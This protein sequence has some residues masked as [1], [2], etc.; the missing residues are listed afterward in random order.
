MT[1]NEALVWLKTLRQRHGE[2]VTLRDENAHSERRF[3]GNAGKE[4]EKT[5]VYDVKELDRRVVKVAMEIRTVEMAIKKANAI[6][7][8]GYSEN[9][10]VLA[11]IA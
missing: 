2:L 4:V 8:I 6:T 10:E 5:P 9:L 11:P 3:Y 1:I 7:E